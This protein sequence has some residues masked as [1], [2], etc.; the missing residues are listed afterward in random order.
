MRK[1]FCNMLHL[2]SPIQYSAICAM[3]NPKMLYIYK[4][5]LFKGHFTG[6]SNSSWE[7]NIVFCRFSHQPVHIYTYTI[8]TLYKCNYIIYSYI[9]IYK[10]YIIIYIIIYIPMNIGL[11][12]PIPQK[13]KNPWPSAMGPPTALCGSTSM[14]RFLRSHEIQ[15]LHKFQ[16]SLDWF[17]GKSTGNHGFYHQ[18]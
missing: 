10:F 5:D 18:I 17:K 14:A 2:F 16:Y 12:A 3:V 13:K 4:L 9:Y 7:N 11:I 15:G 6:K 1:L 8:C